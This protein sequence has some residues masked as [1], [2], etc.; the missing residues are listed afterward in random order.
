MS[1]K[2]AAGKGPRWVW[3]LC[4]DVAELYTHQWVHIVKDEVTGRSWEKTPTSEGH[5]LVCVELSELAG[6]EVKR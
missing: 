4:A 6:D 2:A 1:W 3:L 5:G